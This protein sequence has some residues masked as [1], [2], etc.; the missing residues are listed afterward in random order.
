[1]ECKY[2]GA[3]HFARVNNKLAD[4]QREGATIYYYRCAQCGRDRI[5][6]RF[7]DLLD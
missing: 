2:C 1:M 6:K 4:E 5:I 3:I 7:S